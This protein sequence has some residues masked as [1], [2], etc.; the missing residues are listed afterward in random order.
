MARRLT[1]DGPEPVRVNKWLA[2]QGVCSRRE[3]EGLIE[4][5]LVLIN[6]ETLESPGHKIAPGETLTV[7]DRGNTV[8]SSKLTVV[9][10]KPE[11]IV[12]GTPEGEQIPAVRLLTRNALHGN[13][14][15]IPGRRHTLAPVG[16]LDQDSHGLLILSEDGVVAKAVIGPNSEMDKEYI[17][18][19]RGGISETALDRLRHGLSLDGR[20][21]KRAVVERLGEQ[22]L[23]FVLQEGRNRQIR[24]M[25]DM[26]DIRVI[27]LKRERIGPLELGNLPEGKWRLLS[28]GERTSLVKAG[29]PTTPKQAPRLAGGSGPR[30]D[31]RGK[32]HKAQRQTSRKAPRGPA[33]R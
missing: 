16:R 9:L 20:R 25:C 21:L 18:R 23:R 14:D 13:S 33:K 6:G 27:D 15:V 28:A 31:E 29:Q 2:Q 7:S 10:N 12:S 30:R 1:Y 11:G 17:V 4:A 8:L 5:G 32:T 22:T 19:V 24:R 26:V 3:A